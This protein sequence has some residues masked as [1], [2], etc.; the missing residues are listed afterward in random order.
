MMKAINPFRYS[1]T[2]RFKNRHIRRFLKPQPGERVLDVGSGVGYLCEVL[3]GRQNGRNLFG[4]DVHFDSVRLSQ[5]MAPGTFVAASATALPFQDQ[6]F[7]CINFADVIEHLPDGAAALREMA[8]V[9]RPGARV[10]V[11]TAALEGLFSQTWIGRF[12]HEAHDGVQRHLR[13]GYRGPELAALLR[14]NGFEPVAMRY[15]NYCFTEL[16]IGVA[17]I[18]YRLLRRRYTSQADAVAVSGSLLFQL[19]RFV[20]F[21]LGYLIGRLEEVVLAPFIRGNCVIILSYARDGSP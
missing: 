19:N 14:A 9:A 8:R 13:D 1:L 11:S 3:A 21:P 6:V 5:Q 20:V 16:L 10:A 2:T 12:L 7:D 17:K 4:V 15:T 18:G